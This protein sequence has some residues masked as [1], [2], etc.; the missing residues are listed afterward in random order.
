VTTARQGSRFGIRS[1]HPGKQERDRPGDP[2]NDLAH[3]HLPTVQRPCDEI[4]APN[5]QSPTLR[6]SGNRLKTSQGA[7]HGDPSRSDADLDKLKEQLGVTDRDVCVLIKHFYRLKDDTGSYYA[8]DADGYQLP[9]LS[10]ADW[11]ARYDLIFPGD[12]A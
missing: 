8:T 5:Y 10:P 4:S 2:N 1:Q 6:E 11:H 3:I 9:T 12:A 7:N